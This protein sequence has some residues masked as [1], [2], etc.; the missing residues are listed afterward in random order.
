M[1]LISLA[2]K[3]IKR[4]AT[5]SALSILLMA[6]GL[7]LI[8]FFLVSKRVIETNFNNN[9]AGIHLVVGAKGSPLQLV[10]CNLF[11]VD[12]P[13]GNV[14]I[15]DAKAFLNPKHPLLKKSVPL[16]IGDSHGSHR[17]V[18]TTHDF[19]DLYPLQVEEGRLFES[20]M[21]VVIGANVKEKL[22]LNLSDQFKSSHGINVEESLTHQHDEKFKVVGILK[23]SGTVADELILSNPSSFWQVH[24]DHEHGDHHDHDHHHPSPICNN[25]LDLLQHEDQD[26]TALLMQFK[27]KNV[28]SLNLLRNINTKT[29]LMAASPSFELN[30]LFDQ[31]G[32][33][34][35]LLKYIA[36]MI[37]IISGISIWFGMSISLEDRKYEMALIKSIGGTRTQL[38]RLMLSEVFI[39]SGIGFLLG[40]ILFYIYLW[41]A[42]DSWGVDFTFGDFSLTWYREQFWMYFLSLAIAIASTT[43]A[44]IRIMNLKVLKVLGEH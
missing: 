26:I 28:Q 6:L 3:N 25:N 21:E 33:G 39:I 12:V 7:S 20:N 35:R 40:M 36:A 32:I 42:R 8:C 2:W 18:G 31:L 16:C 14:S 10:L 1:K 5:K 13:T 44:L 4:D 22:Q 43:G 27:G 29:P 37:L 9:L 17:I 38:I 11:H 23:K 15:K 34:F 24:A 30:K 19:F 41:V